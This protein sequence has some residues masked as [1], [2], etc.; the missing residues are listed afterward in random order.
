MGVDQ[1]LAGLTPASD[2]K[3]TDGVNLRSFPAEHWK[4]RKA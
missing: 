3:K 2:A 4:G 1:V